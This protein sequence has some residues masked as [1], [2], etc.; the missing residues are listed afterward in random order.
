MYLFF[1]IFFIIT[2]IF[3]LFCH[4]RK[5]C[6]INKICSMCQEEKCLLL[7]EIIKPFGYQYLPCEDI[8]VSTF[9]A[10]QREFGY[11]HSYNCIAPY[12]HMVFDNE[13]IYFDYKNCTWLIEFWKGQ[14]G[15]NTG[16]EIGIYRADSII[17]PDQRDRAF[18]HT[19]EDDELPV[20]SMK[21][22]RKSLCREQLIADLSMLH[23]WLAAFRMGCF[24]EPGD[25]DIQFCITFPESDMVYAFADALVELE[26]DRCS[27]KICA[28]CISFSY[29]NPMSPS[30]CGFLTR[31][32][33]CI[34][35]RENVFFVKLYLFMTR[36]FSCTLDRL[37]YL[38]YYLP[39]I[40]RHC[41]RLRR[42]RKH[43]HNRGKGGSL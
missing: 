5:A 42:Y 22:T 17:P 16:A 13:E 31:L 4:W 7:N 37:L 23:W 28:S 30:S 35:Q 10:W 12:F 19:V 38:Y 18:F 32:V 20:F 36:T 11:T 2:F 26:Y 39:F 33:R 15:I 24:S 6:I 1:S 8:F 43:R 9:S 21:L 25:L 14:Y 29:R 40:F 34:V 27:F 41:M 3:L